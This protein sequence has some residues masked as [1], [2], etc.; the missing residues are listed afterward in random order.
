[1]SATYDQHKAQLLSWVKLNHPELQHRPLAD[2]PTGA[3]L[4]ASRSLKVPVREL[5]EVRRADAPLEVAPALV[6][7][8]APAAFAHFAA[9]DD[10][11]LLETT[12][13][14]EAV[15]AED[16]EHTGRFVLNELITRLGYHS[17]AFL[18]SLVEAVF[19]AA[20]VLSTGCLS[21]DD[22]AALSRAYHAANLR[23]ATLL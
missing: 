20:E 3:L 8:P 19:D 17:R 5:L 11:V 10:G 12:R 22:E 6:D 4:E 14:V 23:L 9:D 18:D 1:M 13:F 2:L 15:L 21:L 7:A 16:D